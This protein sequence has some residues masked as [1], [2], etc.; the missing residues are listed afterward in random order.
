MDEFSGL[1]LHPSIFSTK[2]WRSASV[3]NGVL[4]DFEWY[5]FN[6]N[7]L[8]PSLVA[9]Q[10][11]KNLSFQIFFYEIQVSFYD[12]IMPSFSVWNL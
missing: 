2:N 7:I 10:P 5:W 4:Y 8:V 11:Y 9:L 6:S 1:F 12:N 3:I